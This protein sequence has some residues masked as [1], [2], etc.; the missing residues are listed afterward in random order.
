M[1]V[2]YVN[3]CVRS[4][5]RTDTL[6]RYAL[7]KIGGE[8]DEVVLNDIDDIAPL[9]RDILNRRGTLLCQ[10]EW[11]NP[12]FCRARQFAEADFI[13]IAA[14]Y[15]DLSFPAL[16]KIYFESINVL[17]ITFSYSSDDVPHSLCKAKSLLYIT[18]AGGKNVPDKYGFGYVKELCRVFYG[19][20]NVMHIK[21]EG[22]GLRSA[23]IEGIMKRAR[24]RIDRMFSTRRLKKK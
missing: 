13:V 3:A 24:S 5:S 2:L 16:L 23:D 14:P 20:G 12:M 18:T 17:G 19:I 22:L 7:K 9:K 11:D 4:D 8:I 1:K 10:E 15:W 6:A 21:A